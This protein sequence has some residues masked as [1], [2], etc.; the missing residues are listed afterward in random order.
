MDER[1]QMLKELTDANGI[2]GNEKEVRAV[3]K[4]H[5]EPFADEVTTDRLGSLVAKK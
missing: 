2:P 5:I 1:L 3:M 4:K